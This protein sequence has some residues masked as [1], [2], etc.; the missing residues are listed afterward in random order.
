MK[1][2]SNERLG[3]V[4]VLLL[5]VHHLQTWNWSDRRHVKQRLTFRCS[6]EYNF[7][8]RQ[9]CPFFYVVQ[10]TSP[11]FG[12]QPGNMKINMHIEEWISICIHF[13]CIFFYA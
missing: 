5:G 13:T 10:A 3:E 6:F 4:S 9:A 11:K 7:A 8:R 12:Q 2:W 1:C